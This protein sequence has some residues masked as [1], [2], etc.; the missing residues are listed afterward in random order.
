LSLFSDYIEELE[1]Y[2]PDIEI[3]ESIPDFYKLGLDV[4]QQN[5][6]LV[7]GIILSLFNH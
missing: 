5:Q 1:S 6:K 3:C 7:I 4:D 2:A